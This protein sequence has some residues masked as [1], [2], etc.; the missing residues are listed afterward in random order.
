[1]KNHYKTLF[2]MYLAL[3][4]YFIFCSVLLFFNKKEQKNGLSSD[5]PKSLM[6]QS[7]GV[8]PSRPMRALD[9]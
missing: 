6:V 1:M 9:P 3:H 4:S 2:K 7:E 8:E 5:N